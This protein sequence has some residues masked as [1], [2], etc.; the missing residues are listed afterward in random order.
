MAEIVKYT[1]Q[2]AIGGQASST[3]IRSYT[4]AA[5]EGLGGAIA[6]IGAQFSQM[7]QQKEDFKAKDG[8]R[9][10]QLQLANDMDT[11]AQD[12]APDGTG[13]HDGFM[14]DV[15]S[16][17][18]DK[19]LESLPQRLREQY[20]TLLGQDGSDTAEWS[21]RGATKE[22]DQLYSWYGNQ[23][24][25]SNEELATAI[26]MDPDGYDKYLKEGTELI[27]QSGLPTGEKTK[28]AR[29]WEH[30]AQ[31]AFL[32]KQL[33]T[34]PEAVLK[35]LGADPRYLTPETQFSMLKDAVVYQESR[36]KANA[37]SPK[38]A[39][40]LMQVMP[41]TA[42]EISKELGDGLV[43]SEMSDERI[44]SIISNPTV[45]QRYGEHYLRKMIRTYGPRGGVEAALIAYNGG[46]KRAEEWIKSGM[47]DS[48][49]PAETRKYY[50][51]IMERLPTT[52]PGTEAGD[53]SKVRIEQ[54]EA[55]GLA[56]LTGKADTRLSK[57][58]TDR[59]QTAFAGL[60]IDRVKVNS[61]FRD[62]VENARVGGAKGSQHQHGNAMDI[63][64]T[65]YSIAERVK[66]I[67]ALSAAGITGLGIGTNIIHADIGGRRAWGYKTSA[68]GGAVPK[69]AAAAIERHL[70]NTSVAP[71]GGTR[72][73]GRFSTLPYSDRQTM[74]AKADQ[75]L[76]QRANE[77]RKQNVVARTQLE[78]NMRN[79]IAALQSTGSSAGS[80]EDTAVSTMLGEERYLK[81]MNEK[82]LALRTFN[83]TNG[84][85]TATPQEMETRVSDYTPDAQSPTF[86]DDQKIA[87]AV[88]K[89][90]DTVMKERS[91]QPDKAALRYPDVKEAYDKVTSA[92][93]PTP[94]EAQEFVRLMLEKQRDF[95]IK[96]G[97]EQPVP[98]AWAMQIGASLSR[99]PEI[100]GNNLQEVNA[101]ILAQYESLQEVFGEYTDEVIISALATYRGVGPNTAEVINQ[102]MKSIQ[103]GGDPLAGARAM[104]DRAQDA[105]Q[106]ESVSN[107]DPL[108]G[109]PAKW[110]MGFFSDA[111]P[112]DP[113][114]AV[115]AEPLAQVADEDLVQRAMNVIGNVDELLPG[116]EAILAQRFGRSVV[117][118]AKERL[119]SQ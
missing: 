84:L 70:S 117:D 69:W 52:S 10:L 112:D 25:A 79:E 47:D 101:G 90:V 87:A 111:E 39:V 105:D 77:D 31:I 5:L 20:G 92:P 16:P 33:E 29:K 97:S 7:Q 75:A 15:Y 6:D 30:M 2:Q 63:D 78:N 85:D 66:I 23:I 13:F 94:A 51:A 113:G 56:T 43:S 106:V 38:G 80:V 14:K 83:A 102:Y 46:G 41:R 4:G 11:R 98:R 40:G 49:L 36:G 109:G 74:I 95:G 3:P 19:F 26:A 24:S 89:K 57:D 18:R 62:P 96:P 34:N 42:V 119:K 27:D 81:W 64:V 104:R 103:A 8:Y 86:A 100:K 72:L 91:S 60:G 45:N 58:L 99:I 44:T 65:G 1:Q 17:A 48:V 93:V 108:I 61:G 53:P 115:P 118:A 12:I 114:D 21:I 116:E 50:K 28:L 59:V 71:K 55:K 68:G 54:S 32:N 82:E 88:Q 73:A 35:Q 76:T 9:K 110:I 67:E 37:I 22:R 107:E